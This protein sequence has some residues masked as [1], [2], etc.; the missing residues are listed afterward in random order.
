M[1]CPK[2]VFHHPSVHLRLL[3]SLSPSPMMSSEGGDINV[4]FNSEHPTVSCPQHPDHPRVSALIAPWCKENLPRWWP[5]TALVYGYRY[6]QLEGSLATC[7]LS[8]TKV[9]CSPL[10]LWPPESWAF[11]AFWGAQRQA[12]ASFCGAGIR[13]KCKLVGYP[14]NRCT[15]LYQEAPLIW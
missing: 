9:V 11:E 1:P 2:T 12:C 14:D 6:K 8:K 3:H 15:M 4:P 5:R 10:V 13:S 7:S